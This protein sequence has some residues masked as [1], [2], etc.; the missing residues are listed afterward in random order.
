[1]IVAPFTFQTL[2][3][4][5]SADPVD[6]IFGT[7]EEIR[8]KESQAICRAHRQGQYKV[9]KVTRLITL[10][11]VEEEQHKY[12]NNSGPSAQNDGGDHGKGQDESK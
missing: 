9:I 2:F 11:T 6:P 4:F 10:G 1:M 3:L 7:A 8:A 5:W 12:K